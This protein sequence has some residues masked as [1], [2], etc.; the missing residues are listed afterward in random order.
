MAVLL[1]KIIRDVIRV[2]GGWAVNSRV[3]EQ[4]KELGSRKRTQNVLR[5][6]LERTEECV[7]R[8]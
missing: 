2:Y 8:K 3:E 6:N 1:G 4:K 5:S 7:P